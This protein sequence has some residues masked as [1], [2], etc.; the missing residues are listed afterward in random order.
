MQY[1]PTAYGEMNSVSGEAQ[2]PAQ[3]C[4]SHCEASHQK[5]FLA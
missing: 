1:K 3:E 4:S 5:A 2:M